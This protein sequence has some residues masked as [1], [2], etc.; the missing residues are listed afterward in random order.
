MRNITYVEAIR[1][2]MS[3]EMRANQD[4]FILG[5]D[6]G[7]YGG[8]FGVTN[9]MI[10]EFGPERVR[11]TPISEAAISGCAVGAAM[12]GMRPILELQF[13]DFITIAMDNIV[14]QAAKMR[15]MFGGKANVPV[16]IRTPGGSGA[17][18]AAQHSQSLEAW[19][20]HI[21]GLK[22]V[23]PSTPY[24]AK[25]LLKAAI[26]DDNPV[27]FYEHKMLYGVRG[28]VPEETYEIPLGKAD[29]KKEGTDVT[30]VATSMMVHKSLEAAK[31]LEE[32]GISVEVIDPRTL[33]PLDK[34]TILHSVRKTGRVIVV[35]E[36]V[37]RGG[38]GAEI[39]S[40][41]GESD[42]FDY[43]DAPI[44]RLGGRAV[45]MP[46]NAFLEQKA[47]PQ[48]EDIVQACKTIMNK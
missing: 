12:T 38:Y 45:P 9:G 21:P 35:Y 7:I 26:N 32:E 42:V 29:I 6:I 22:V 2:A 11:N 17:G 19:M 1:E 33:V 46:Y 20:A 23:Q 41:I 4:V 18:F 16:V 34:E 47:V 5:E 31:L 3:Q 8:A 14:N 40:M 10:E 36:A 24:D 48:V 44:M 13:S 39:A 37:K 43:L 15:Y 30:I 27:M 25:G 28:D